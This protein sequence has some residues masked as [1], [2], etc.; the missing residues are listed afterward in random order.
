MDNTE[1]LIRIL[2]EM[3]SRLKSQQETQEKEKTEHQELAIILNEIK[4][5]VDKL[6]EAVV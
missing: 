5:D 6:K 3:L 2:E 1:E 4:E